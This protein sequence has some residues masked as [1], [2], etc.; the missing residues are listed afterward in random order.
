MPVARN[1]GITSLVDIL[2]RALDQGIRFDVRP[3]A[4]LASPLPGTEKLRITVEAV[5]T[6]LEAPAPPPGLTGTG[7]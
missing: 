7:A 4:T 1:P 6:H 2:D 5:D 3:N